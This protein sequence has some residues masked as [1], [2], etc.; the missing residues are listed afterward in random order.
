L[1]KIKVLLRTTA[2]Q[3]WTFLPWQFIINLCFRNIFICLFSNIQSSEST[4]SWS[5][6]RI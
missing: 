5:C 2:N 3:E 1:K 4:V 6:T